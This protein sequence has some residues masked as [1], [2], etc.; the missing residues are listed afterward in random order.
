MLICTR[1]VSVGG[2]INDLLLILSKTL[3]PSNSR[4]LKSGSYQVILD[5]CFSI[6]ILKFKEE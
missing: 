4:G 3:N 2:I 6:S 1:E 5:N